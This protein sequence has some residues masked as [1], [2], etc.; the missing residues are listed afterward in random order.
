L[1][2]TPK[3]LKEHKALVDEL[4]SL[5]QELARLKPKLDRAK[6]LREVIAGWYADE[7]PEA[8]MLA[9]GN[10]YS[11]IVSPMGNKRTVTSMIA[12]RKRLG[13]REFMAH[14]SIG[15]GV[16]DELLTVEE[17]PEFVESERSGPRSVK[18]V[19]KAA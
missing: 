12:V 3:E 11:A 14:C 10:A 6:W 2:L 19:A 1:K 16:L 5:D 7:K 8:A 15:L 17:L 4:G 9:E 13:D 18:T